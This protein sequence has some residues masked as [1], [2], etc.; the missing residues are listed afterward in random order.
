MVNQE[1]DFTEFSFDIKVYRVFNKTKFGSSKKN[2]S[3]NSETI[4]YQ[5]EMFCLNDPS[6]LYKNTYPI[7]LPADGVEDPVTIAF[8]VFNL[9]HHPFDTLD[10]HGNVRSA[11]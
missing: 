5:I 10:E 1:F 11:V 4:C 6:V 7:K 9:V 3:M 2:L 8:N